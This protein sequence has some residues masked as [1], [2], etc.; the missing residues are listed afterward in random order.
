MYKLI[1]VAGPNRGKSFRVQAGEN[2]IGRHSDNVI[3]LPSAKVS[4]RHCVLVVN[5]EGMTVQDQGSANGTFVNGVLARAKRVGPGDRISVGEFV[6]EVV[7]PSERASQARAQESQFAPQHNVV[8]MPGVDLGASGLP[9]FPAN[10]GGMPNGMPENTGLGAHPLH[11]APN[12]LKGKVAF[13]FE[14]HVMPVFYGLNLK[15]EWR[16]IAGSLIGGLVFL[17]ALLTIFPLVQSSQNAAKRESGR[18]AA[19]MAREIAH[20]NGGFLAAQA[21][22]KTDVGPA[23][24]AQ[25]VRIAMLTDLELRIIAPASKLNQYLASGEEAVF[26]KKARDQF[27]T[28]RES[29]LVFFGSSSVVAAEPVKVLNPAYGRNVVIG[30]AIVSIENSFA[31]SEVGDLGLVLSQ[32]LILT[33]LLGILVFFILYRL[34]VKPL[35][36]L[37][38]DMD[39][40][41]KGEIDQVTHEFKSEETNS[42][43]DLINSAIQRVSTQSPQGDLS[44]DA[45]ATFDDFSLVGRLVGQIAPFGVVVCDSERKIQYANE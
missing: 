22:S 21:E 28:G 24:T 39:K 42:L 9:A 15:Y 17:S 3:V 41:L 29:G 27:R 20:R 43:W 13:Y 4:K 30:M 10:P 31:T 2:G 40:A 23:E 7:K 33:G 26:A 1:V 38:D 16:F 6:L 45:G 37:G 18:R 35:Q 32:T 25:G 12:D 34:T 19:F 14:N 5:N 44:A 36:V 8:P 11:E